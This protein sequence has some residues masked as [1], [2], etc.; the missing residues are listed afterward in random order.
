[1][2]FLPYQRLEKD[3]EL[4]SLK[5]VKVSPRS[6]WSFKDLKDHMVPKLGITGPGRTV[7]FANVKNG[8][9]EKLWEET[10]FITEIEP[11]D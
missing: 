8:R 3:G 5:P 11:R 2:F 7:V 6:S 4:T 10:D 1:V 9:I